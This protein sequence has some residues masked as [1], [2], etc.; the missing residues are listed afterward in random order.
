M[1]QLLASPLITTTRMGRFT[2]LITVLALLTG[3]SSTGTGV[4][5]GGIATI[6]KAVMNPFKSVEKT[7]EKGYTGTAQALEG[8]GGGEVASITQSDNPEATSAQDFNSTHEEEITFASATI[9]KEQTVDSNGATVTK[10]IEVPAGSKRTVK[11]TQTVNQTIGGSR[12][13]T[14][15][16]TSNFLASFKWVQGLGIITLLIGAI[17]FAHPL[18][19]ALVGGKDTAIVVSLCGVGMIAGPY[20]LVKYSDWFALG[21]VA[22]ALY[23]FVSRAKHKEGQLDAIQ[24]GKTNPPFPR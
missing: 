18:A 22:A 19:R 23:W 16:Q 11:D 14:S 9:I 10:I 24:T 15:A 2:L 4:V 8:A 3:C 20:L 1:G 7:T 13:D 17:G 5:R 6:G 12:G 21:L